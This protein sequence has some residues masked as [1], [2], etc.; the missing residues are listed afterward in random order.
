MRITSMALATV[1]LATTQLFALPT[2]DDFE[3]WKA[4]VWDPIEPEGRYKFV[5]HEPTR[6]LGLLFPENPGSTLSTA[7]RLL[8]VGS[9]EFQDDLAWDI[10]DA[11]FNNGWSDRWELSDNGLT[12]EFRPLDGSGVYLPAIADQSQFWPGFTHTQPP[13]YSNQLPV[14]LMPLARLPIGQTLTS[15]MVVRSELGLVDDPS[16]FAVHL[17]FEVI[18]EPGTVGIL[19][20]GMLLI[21]RRWRTRESG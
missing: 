17:E 2:Q 9:I 11:V 12:I 3:N 21:C 19:G 10:S 16:Q 7:G 8:T 1:L 15:E 18:P 5:Y 4:G 13:S 14:T 20:V 6:V